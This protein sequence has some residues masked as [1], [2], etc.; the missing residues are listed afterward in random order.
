MSMKIHPLAHF[1]REQRERVA[2]VIFDRVGHC[3]Y[4][5]RRFA[6]GRIFPRAFELK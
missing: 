6:F 4:T 1:N 3:E 2:G 5:A